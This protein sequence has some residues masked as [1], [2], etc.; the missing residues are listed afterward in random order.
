MNREMRLVMTLASLGHAA[1]NRA[2]IKV[3]QPL[4]EIA[5]SVS[6]QEESLALER[7]ADLLAE[8]LN[9]KG[10]RRLGSAGEAVTYYLKPLPKQL[11]QKYKALFPKVRQAI[12]R[13]ESGEAARSLLAGQTI[14]VP[15]EGIN[16]DI[17]PDEVEVRAED[18]GRAGGRRRRSLSGR[19]AY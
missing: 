17:T 11:G 15:V 14:Q 2:G 3:R 8:E 13:I 5:F 12:E 6:S 18:A 19:P 7:H 4:A 10:V 1:R 9:V 16:L